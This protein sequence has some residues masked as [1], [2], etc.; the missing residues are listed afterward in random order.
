MPARRRGAEED[1]M[2]GPT[3][4]RSS[5]I[6][7]PHG[8]STVQQPSRR[9]SYAWPRYSVYHTLPK[10]LAE[11][12]VRRAQFHHLLALTPYSLTNASE[13]CNKSRLAS[14]GNLGGGTNMAINRD[15]PYRTRR[16]FPNPKPQNKGQRGNRL[17]F[18]NLSTVTFGMPPN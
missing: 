18:F 10:Y 16:T 14:G 8:Q 1:S 9:V 5:S 7:I 12:W 2:L 13:A 6:I 3:A 15:E 17:H 4:L 11:D